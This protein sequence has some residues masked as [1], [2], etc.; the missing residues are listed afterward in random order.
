M[1]TDRILQF[2]LLLVALLIATYSV[3]TFTSSELFSSPITVAVLVIFIGFLPVVLLKRTTDTVMI[4]AAYL[5]LSLYSISSAIYLVSRLSLGEA[6][7]SIVSLMIAGT[8]LAGVYVIRQDSIIL[9]QERLI[10]I[11]VV[12]GLSS[13]GLATVDIVSEEPQEELV[14]VEQEETEEGIVIAEVRAT[15]PSI[16]PKTYDSKSYQAC[17]SEEMSGQDER[18]RPRN[19]AYTEISDNEVVIGNKTEKMV[20]PSDEFILP[21]DGFDIQKT[22]GCPQNLSNNT[23][24]VY[25][26][27]T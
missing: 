14:K 3:I 9:T 10:A 24:A 1:D 15:N 4:Y 20:I 16:L 2:A 19:I 25:S 22:S 27:G 17:I 18:I 13:V 5:V 7:M 23:V 8:I 11:M 6:V 12:L 26:T 21:E